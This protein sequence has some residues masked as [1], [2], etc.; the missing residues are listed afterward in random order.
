MTTTEIKKALYK[1]K[2]M[3][4]VTNFDAFSDR[5]IYKATLKNKEVITFEIPRIEG[6]DF[7]DEMEAQLL[8]RWL[9][10]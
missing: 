3:A 6:K 9:K 8:I 4:E 5:Y 2:P 1:E 7:K 10:N